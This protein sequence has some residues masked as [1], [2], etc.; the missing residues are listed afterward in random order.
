MISHAVPITSSSLCVLMVLGMIVFLY[1]YQKRRL[2][3]A[4]DIPADQIVVRLSTIE[5]RNS[6]GN[7]HVPHVN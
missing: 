5:N 2:I 6:G 7:D 3:P 4:R 1:F